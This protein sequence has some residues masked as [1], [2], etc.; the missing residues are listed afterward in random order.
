MDNLESRKKLSDSLMGHGMSDE[1]REKKRTSMKK[2]PERNDNPF[3]GK[4]HT[5]EF[6]ESQSKLKGTPISL[7]G[8][9]YNGIKHAARMLGITEYFIKKQLQTQTNESTQ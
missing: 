9:D 6:K 2:W 5:D 7:N 1:T 8:I 4:S 3:L